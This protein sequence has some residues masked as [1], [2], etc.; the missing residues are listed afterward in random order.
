MK[1]SKLVIYIIAMCIWAYLQISA[2]SSNDLIHIYDGVVFDSTIVH[3]VRCFF[4]FACYSLYTHNE[5]ETYIN[6]YGTI[7]VI[8][9]NSR[10]KFFLHFGRRLLRLV[11]QIEAIRIGCYTA[12][13]IVMK[14]GVTINSPL[15]LFTSVFLNIFIYFFLLFIQM[16][17]EIWCSG[18]IAVVITLVN[19]LIGLG[20]S[21]I[22]D[23]SQFIS[24]KINILLI[25][26][27]TMRIRVECLIENEYMILIIVGGLLLCL[28]VI[29]AVAKM[30]FKEKDIL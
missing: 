24:N 23:R 16:L 11:L 29:Y 21:D 25:Q 7:L 15:L 8:R 3:Y 26:N 13:M 4:L 30:C 17:V 27:L 2:G 18:K 5:F 19:F 10:E 9:E 28:G 1:K 20:I 12:L 14:Q 6:Q 22:I